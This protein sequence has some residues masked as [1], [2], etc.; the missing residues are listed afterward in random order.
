LHSKFKAFTLVELLVVI[1]I[2]G[3]LIALLLPAVQAAREAARRMQCSNNL[4]QLGLAMHNYHDVHNALP[5]AWFGYD[6]QNRPAPL[7]NPGWSWGTAI[8]P[9]AEQSNVQNNLV[10]YNLPITADENEQA[11]K[12]VLKL[13]RCPSDSS[14]SNRT[15][16][17]EEFEEQHGHEHEE[18]EGEE[19]EF[20]EMKFALANYIVNFGTFDSDEAE[21]FAE[22][23]PHTIFKTDGVFY[24]NSCLNLAAITDGLSNTLFIGER[25]SNVGLQ[26]WVGMPPDDG[27]FPALLV[28]STNDAEG[29]PLGKKNGSPHGFSSEH[30]GGANFTFGDGS[31]RFLS[32]TLDVNLLKALSTRGGGESASP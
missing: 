27:C 31:V 8:L 10:H 9:F 2:I 13:F 7:G 5:A 18:S 26:T 32:E 17:I 11:R 1:A 3:V 24:H 12:T 21:Q 6:A 23:N 19:G 20:H 16:T 25:T 4:K 22:D 28:G 14:P 15:F 29:K 30:P